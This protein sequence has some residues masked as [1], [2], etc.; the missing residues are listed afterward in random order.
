MATVNGGSNNDTLTGTSSADTLNGY[1]GNDSIVGAAGADVASGG[2]GNDSLYGGTEND[3]LT[4]ETGSDYLDGGT[5]ADML[6]GGQSADTIYGGGDNDFILG[7]GQW[8]SAE[9]SSGIIGATLTVTNNADGPVTLGHWNVLGT[10]VENTVIQ[11]GQ[12][13]TVN[14][15]SG[16]NFVLRDMDGYYLE[17]I[18]VNGNTTVS[19]G[20]DLADHIY[21]G[22]GNDTIISQY[23]NDTVFGGAGA[24]S[25]E[26]GYGNDSF[27]SFADDESG[28]DT[29]YGGAGN[30]SIIA[31]AG[32]DS[33]FGGDGNDTL[34]GHTGNDSL[35]GGTGDDSFQITDDH[36]GD[37]I[38]GGTGNDWLLFSTFSTTQ[39]VAVTL[40]GSG[41]GSYDFYGSSGAGTFTSVEYFVGTDYADS[42]DATASTSFVALAGGGGNDTIRGGSASDYLYGGTGNDTI[43]GGGGNDSFWGEDGNDSIIGAAGADVF[44]GGAGNDTFAGGS[45]ND[46]YYGGT[47]LDVLDFSTSFAAVNVNLQT[48]TL[49]GGDATGDVIGFGV[50]GIIGS[51]YNDTLTGADSENFSSPDIYT[52]YIDGGAG[53]DIIDGRGGSDTLIGGS[54]ADT[55]YG[56]SGN[57]SITGGTGNDSID[58]GAGNDTLLGGDGTDTFVIAEGA[59]TDTITGGESAGDA[60]IITFTTTSNLTVTFTGAEAGTYSSSS[61]VTGT[62]TE[63]E[64]LS[65][66]SGNDTVNAAASGSGV[67]ITAGAGADS[68]TG[69]A[70]A[71]TIT[72]GTGSD[73][74]TGGAGNDSLS[75]GDDADRFVVGDG[76]GIDT[77]TGGEGGTDSDWLVFGGSVG[78][79]VTYTGNESGNYT[80][81]S[82]TSG[83][84]TEIEYL[85]GGSGNDTINAAASN[86]A[87]RID[88]GAGNDL[89]T[90]GVVADTLIGGSGN[91]TIRGGGGNDT[92]T[93]GDGAD[94]VDLAQFGGRDTITDFNM[95]LVGNRAIDQLDV[96]ELRTLTNQTINWR[97]VVVTDTVG[98]GSG[99]AILTFPNGEQVVLT[100]VLASSVDSKLEMARIGI[101]CFG[102]GTPILTPSGWRMVDDLGAGDV[103]LDRDGVPHEIAWAGRRHILADELN[104]RPGLKP[105]RIA[106][107]ALGNDRVITV[108][109]QHA[110]L[111]RLNRREDVLVRAAHLA[112]FGNGGFR[113]AEGVREVTYHHLLLPHHAILVV[114]GA[115]MESMYPGR[116]AVANLDLT[117]QVEVARTIR[118]LRGLNTSCPYATGTLA[119]YYGKPVARVLT[120]AEARVALAEN[121]LSPAIWYNES[122]KVSA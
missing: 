35:Y 43:Y 13:V 47:G 32:N 15:F 12:T 110:V 116:Q 10:W 93:L 69:S 24:D 14:T 115:L 40:T 103:V 9:A 49:T 54:G 88:G 80:S 102:A 61:G 112:Q 117:A 86:S 25:V 51:A 41:A 113:V 63:I 90:G 31:G 34:S 19:Y 59:E 36:D 107:W 92:L 55:I 5:G 62:F 122:S 73:T 38:D 121:R 95:T 78:V 97:D 42:L 23:G 70:S 37:V 108:S 98:D 106:R 48:N 26:L 22:D 111:M 84:F 77:I 105:V 87:V 39:G 1:G 101:P 118:A 76:A 28:N 81:A 119:A 85:D 21:G 6:L 8:Y 57:D 17:W 11:P 82:G 60:D 7:D 33:V 53:D 94:V 16:Y 79:S 71:D 67:F 74:I 64:Q 96:N 114:G 109:R 18:D 27:G 50:D 99:S 46:T 68:I 120:G 2:A 100:G 29:I 56:G 91:D 65:L 52:T 66:G 83:Q 30:D 89:I 45:G 20:G 72:G 3:T 104:G 44:D 75:G 4:G 58:G